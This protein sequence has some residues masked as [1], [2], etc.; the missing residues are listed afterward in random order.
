M[1]IP[2]FAELETQRLAGDHNCDSYAVGIH[3]N[4]RFYKYYWWVFHKDSPCDGE[5]LLSKSYRLNFAAAVRLMDRLKEAGEACWVYNREHPRRDLE[6][7][8]WDFEASLWKSVEW[9]LPYAHDPDPVYQGH[10]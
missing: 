1:R 9:A 5:K 4:P 8:P 3:P 6:N 7:T 10:K 2:N